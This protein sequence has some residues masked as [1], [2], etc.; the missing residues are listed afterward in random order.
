M[1]ASCYAHS[2]FLLA[3]SHPSLLHNIDMRG[4]TLMRWMDFSFEMAMTQQRTNRLKTSSKMCSN[5]S[6]R[7][8]TS[9]WRRAQRAAH[10][11]STR[12]VF[13]VLPLCCYNSR[14]C[15]RGGAPS[16][17]CAPWR[18]KRRV[19]KGVTVSLEAAM[20]APAP[21]ARGPTTAALL[22]LVLAGSRNKA[23][24]CELR[25]SLTPV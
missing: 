13:C 9:R 1:F 10:L 24:R 17:G 15:W 23:L 5:H 7:D 20:R 21:S 3:S 19:G 22:G 12:S 14:I 8:A 11:V 25:C 16:H 2:Y 4:W 18:R 6:M